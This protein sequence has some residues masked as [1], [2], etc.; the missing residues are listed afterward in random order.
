MLTA[1]IIIHVLLIGALLYRRIWSCVPYMGLIALLGLGCSPLLHYAHPR[2]ADH[3]YLLL[4]YSIDA[5][6]ALLYL[7]S[8]LKLRTTPLAPI[9]ISQLMYLGLKLLAWTFLL[10][11]L[12]TPRVELTTLMRPLNLL[13]ICF[14]VLV[15]WHYH[16]PERRSDYASEP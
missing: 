11:D 8:I 7:F 16:E 14:W 6:M 5:G 1:A 12:T 9:A 3:P 4:Y 2:I 10:F 13:F 15:I